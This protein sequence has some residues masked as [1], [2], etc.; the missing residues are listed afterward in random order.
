MRQFCFGVDVGG[1]TVKLGLFQPDGTLVEKWEIPTVT[2]NSGEQILP[3]IAAS[4]QEKMDHH[5][6]QK[7]QVLGIGLGVP[8]PVASDGIIYGAVNLGWGIFNIH[9]ELSDLT[10]LKVKAGNDATIAALGEMWQGAGRGYKNVILATL[11]T[12]VGGGIIIDGQILSG[13]KGAAGEIG[14]MHVQDNEEEACSCGNFG[15][16]E[17]YASATGIVRMAN[18]ILRTSD[19]NSVLRTDEE[20]ISAKL[21][22]DA[23]KKGDALAIEVAEIFGK[24]LGTAMA[25]VAN[26]ADPEIILFGGGVSKAGEIILQYINKYYVLYAFQEAKNIPLAIATLGNDAGIYGGAKLIIN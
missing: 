17:Q 21:V 6:I 13:F 25:N 22:F 11:G 20:G 26:I 23:V 1:T 14:H 3:D 10:G 9:K 16:L 8:G 12:G 5:E 2:Q 18:K 7:E 15:C 19:Q 4:I 24:Y